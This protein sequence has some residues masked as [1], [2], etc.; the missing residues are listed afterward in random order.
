MNNTN[1]NSAKKKVNYFD[2]TTKSKDVVLVVNST[3]TKQKDT[4]NG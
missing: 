1:V 3:K 2:P 4:N